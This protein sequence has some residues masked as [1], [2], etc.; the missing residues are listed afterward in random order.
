MFALTHMNNWTH[1]SMYPAFIL[2]GESRK[3]LLPCPRHARN[4]RQS[5]IHNVTCLGPGHARNRLLAGSTWRCIV[6]LPWRQECSLPVCCGFTHGAVLTVDPPTKP[7]LLHQQ[8]TFVC[9]FALHATW[10]SVL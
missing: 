1:A 4:I 6:V 9:W 5:H 7:L 10:Q 8:L 2:S 3:A